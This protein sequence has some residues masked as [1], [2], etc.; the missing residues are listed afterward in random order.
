MSGDAEFA[1]FAFKALW[2]VA[3]GAVLG[4]IKLWMD[5]NAFKLRLAEQGSMSELK[6]EVR[7]IRR[8]V[9]RIATRLHIPATHD[10]Q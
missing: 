4:L 3:S 9:D 8:V 7:S 6:E 10:E 1:S 5:F 2:A